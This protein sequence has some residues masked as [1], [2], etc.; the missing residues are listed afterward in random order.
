MV[1]MHALLIC[2]LDFVSVRGVSISLR[3]HFVVNADMFTLPLSAEDY[4]FFSASSA[5]RFAAQIFCFLSNLPLSNHWVLFTPSDWDWVTVCHL[6][7][8]MTAIQEIVKTCIM[9]MLLHIWTDMT[10]QALV[11]VLPTCQRKRTA[12]IIYLSL[13]SSLPLK[14]EDWCLYKYWHMF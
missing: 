7:K 5:Y 3:T 9:H 12:D 2:I 1:C 8:V 6:Y 10:G 14:E 13:P 4:R 11:L